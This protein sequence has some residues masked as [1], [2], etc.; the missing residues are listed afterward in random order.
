MALWLRTWIGRSRCHTGAHEALRAGRR[1]L[2][3]HS[4]SG[5]LDTQPTLRSHAQI[6]AGRKPRDNSGA[7]F[8]AAHAQSRTPAGSG[9]TPAPSLQRGAR[10]RPLPSAR[11]RAG[12]GVTGREHPGPA[13]SPSPRRHPHPHPHPHSVPGSPTRASSLSLRGGTLASYSTRALVGSG[14]KH[15]TFSP[16]WNL[17]FMPSLA[18]ICSSWRRARLRGGRSARGGGQGGAGRWCTA[19]GGGREGTGNG[20]GCGRPALGPASA[21][22]KSPLD[23]EIADRALCPHPAHPQQAPASLPR[24]GAARDRR[25]PAKAEVCQQSGLSRPRGKGS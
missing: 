10:E 23:L 17:N 2:R 25:T 9:S 13:A 15:R 11:R 21:R 22:P 8:Q 6:D 5:F 18:L 24:A 1:D 14:S 19:A 12:P 7:S 16:E 3:R 20:G 4:V